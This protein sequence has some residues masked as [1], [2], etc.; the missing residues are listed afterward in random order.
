MIP[1]TSHPPVPPS[2]QVSTPTGHSRRVADL[3][4]ELDEACVESVALCLARV[5]ERES[6][7]RVESMRRTLH[8]SNATVAN[9]CLDL[10]TRR[11]NVSVL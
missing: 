10:E 4:R 5:S 8:Y 6:A 1:L 11:G 3:E 9:L 2:L 7:V